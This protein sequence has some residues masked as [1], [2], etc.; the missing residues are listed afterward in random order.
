M[1]VEEYVVDRLQK[2]EQDNE[3]F[4]HAIVKQMEKLAE[5]EGKLSRIKEVLQNRFKYHM[6]DEKVGDYVSIHECFFYG[7]AKEVIELFDLSPIA[8]E[9]SEE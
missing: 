1:T 6:N 7:E 2:L 8:E 4:A 3:D 9:E 5:A